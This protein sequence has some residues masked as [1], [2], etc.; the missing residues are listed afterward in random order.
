MVFQNRNTSDWL[1]EYNDWS[2]FLLIL[3]TQTVSFYLPK[4]QQELLQQICLSG[5]VGEQTAVMS[6]IHVQKKKPFKVLLPE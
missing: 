3:T 6:N 4:N 2:V 1:T 5:K